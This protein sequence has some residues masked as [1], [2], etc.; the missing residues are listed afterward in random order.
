MRF[1]PLKHSQ[2]QGLAKSIM[3][4]TFELLAAQASRVTVGGA[5]GAW[6]GDRPRLYQMPMPSSTPPPAEAGHVPVETHGGPACSW[7]R[8]YHPG[9]MRG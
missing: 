6:G 9:R 5:D 3:G 1:E 2:F 4:G 8:R 7:G